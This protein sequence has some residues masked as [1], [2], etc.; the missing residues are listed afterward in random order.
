MI[1]KLNTG[2]NKATEYAQDAGVA[3]TKIKESLRQTT[4]QIRFKYAPSHK[5]IV[6]EFKNNLAEYLIQQCYIEANKIRKAVSRGDI[7]SNL[8]PIRKYILH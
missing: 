8:E 3:M 7:E 4:V 5:A 1:C 6:K 2:L